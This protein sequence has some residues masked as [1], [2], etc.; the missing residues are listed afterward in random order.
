M[1]QHRPDLTFADGRVGEI[2]TPKRLLALVSRWDADQRREFVPG[3]DHDAVLYLGRHLDEG[4]LCTLVACMTDRQQGWLNEAYGI[5]DC[6][7]PPDGAE[8]EHHRAARE[9]SFTLPWVVIYVLLTERQRNGE[10]GD[11]TGC[12][13]EEI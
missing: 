7:C 4:L 10:D 3:L 2:L 13:Y 5:L 12:Y 1:D 8:C 6:D 9:R 11:T